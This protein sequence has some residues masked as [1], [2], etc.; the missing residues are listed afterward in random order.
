MG[1]G[2]KAQG[3]IRKDVN[4][5]TLF[6]KVF[7]TDKSIRQII[8]EYTLQRHFIPHEYKISTVPDPENP[9]NEVT[10]TLEFDER[11]GV[12]DLDSG[13]SVGDD[14]AFAQYTSGE[15]R[16]AETHIV[17]AELVGEGSVQRKINAELQY[18]HSEDRLYH[19]IFFNYNRAPVVDNGYKVCYASSLRVPDFRQ[20]GEAD[21][22]N[23]VNATSKL[24]FGETCENGAKLT[25]SARFSQNEEQKR[26]ERERLSSGQNPYSN[27]YTQCLEKR[28]RADAMPYCYEYLS[29]VAKGRSLVVD[30][31]HEKIRETIVVR[32]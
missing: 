24:A 16:K 12:A 22:D 15:G 17:K 25:V 21:L 9:I 5:R 19:K 8:A 18:S 26:V 20:F 10:F 31:E 4:R 30:I 7:G 23:S 27:A 14:D 28:P 13:I 2:I 3:Q 11:D 1:Y 32:T 6:K 29:L